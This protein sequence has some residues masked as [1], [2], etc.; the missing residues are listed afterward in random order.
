MDTSNGTQNLSG[1]KVN[2]VLATTKYHYHYQPRQQGLG[3]PLQQVAHQ[4]VAD[5]DA[6]DL[7]TFLT[8]FM[9]KLNTYLI[10]LRVAKSSGLEPTSLPHSTTSAR[11]ATRRRHIAS[12]RRTITLSYPKRSSVASIPSEPKTRPTPP[13]RV[14]FKALRGR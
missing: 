7:H 10:M 14:D 3:D 4:E 9:L 11:W 2:I 5:R 6:L 1:L 13:K 8:L 12:N